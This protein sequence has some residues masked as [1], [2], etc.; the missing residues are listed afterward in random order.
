M[1]R[2]TAAQ[3]AEQIVVDHREMATLLALRRLEPILRLEL[4][5]H[6]LRIVL[7]VASGAATTGR[8]I[9]EALRVSAPAVSSSVDKLVELGFIERDSSDPDR[10]VK[11]L[12][13]SAK[14]QALV[15]QFLGLRDTTDEYLARLERDDLEALARG[16]AALRRAMESGP[17]DD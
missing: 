1:H 9:A 17:A 4:T 3:L 5:L 2:F 13:P 12:A 7:L 8:E 10:R 14:S 11:H 15:D 16:T 6:Q